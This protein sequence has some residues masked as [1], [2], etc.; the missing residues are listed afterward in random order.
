MR[1]D[2]DRAAGLRRGAGVVS[3]G[4]A[5]AS[6]LAEAGAHIDCERFVRPSVAIVA[7]ILNV[8][9]FRRAPPL[10]GPAPP[11]PPGAYLL[12]RICA[13][14]VVFNATNSCESFVKAFLCVD[15]N[16]RDLIIGI[17]VYTRVRSAAGQFRHGIAFKA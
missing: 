8:S 2:C 13:T 9:V 5:S 7:T 14:V 4:A 17:I 3:I 15:M 16:R 6:I 11:A 1:A 12:H 10:P